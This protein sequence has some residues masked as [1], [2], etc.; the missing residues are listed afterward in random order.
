MITERI[1]PDQTLFVNDKPNRLDEKMTA[2]SSGKK[3]SYIENCV[4]N[5]KT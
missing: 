1:K 3:K 2:L 5:G 4:M